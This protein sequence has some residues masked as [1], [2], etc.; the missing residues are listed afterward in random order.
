MSELSLGM[1]YMEAADQMVM[2]EKLFWKTQGTCF[3]KHAEEDHAGTFRS[4]I[5]PFLITG[6]QSFYTGRPG[7]P[8]SHSFKVASDIKVIIT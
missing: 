2:M 1:D 8:T 7:Y 3:S 5:Q 4:V 6:G